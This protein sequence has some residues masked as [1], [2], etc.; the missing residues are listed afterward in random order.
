MKTLLIILVS[1]I[2]TTPCLAQTNEIK[3][4]PL[5]IGHTIQLVSTVLH[6][7]RT[8]NVALPEGYDPQED[9]KYPVIYILDGGRNEDFLHIAGLVKYNTQPWIDRFPKSIVVGIENLNRRRDFTFKV[10]N[11]DF[12]ESKKMKKEYFSASGASAPYIDFLQNELIPYIT[13]N[14]KTTE[15]RTVIGESL[16]GLLATEILLRHPSTFNDYI[17]ISPSLWWDDHSLIRE[18][19]NLKK[20]TITQPVKVYIGA[21]DR[22]EDIEMYD[23]ALQLEQTLKRLHPKIQLSFDYLPGELHSTVIH[24]AVYNA[25]R[26]LYP[27][28]VYRQ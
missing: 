14:Y 26:L 11:L 5:T 8:I 3:N 12:L 18:P 23:S 25:F 7:N 13:Q 22:E 1:L 20:E 27:K 4:T 10:N 16:A 9:Q 6:E 17:I 21:P 15:H 28:T 19:S 24:Q 2:A